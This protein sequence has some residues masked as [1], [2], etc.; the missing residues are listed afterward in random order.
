[1]QTQCKLTTK[2]NSKS[3][4]MGGFMKSIRLILEAQIIGKII[5]EWLCGKVRS[6]TI[7]EI[8]NKFYGMTQEVPLMKLV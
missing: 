3:F 5:F 6:I 1:M 7:V 4:R 8:I 2:Y